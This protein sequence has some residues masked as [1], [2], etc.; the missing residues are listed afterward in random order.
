MHNKRENWKKNDLKLEVQTSME[1]VHICSQIINV[2]SY[3]KKLLKSGFF[4]HYLR[5]QKIAQRRNFPKR[6]IAVYRLFSTKNLRNHWPFWFVGCFGIFQTS[7]R[8][9]WNTMRTNLA[10]KPTNKRAE[11]SRPFAGNLSSIMIKGEKIKH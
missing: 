5:Y 1:K 2:K 7:C 4:H 8:Q 6:Q 11:P 3:E 10:L 9:L